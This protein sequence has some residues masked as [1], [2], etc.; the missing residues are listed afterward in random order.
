MKIFCE[1]IIFGF[2]GHLLLSTK[3]NIGLGCPHNLSVKFQPDRSFIITVE[4]CH[5]CGLSKKS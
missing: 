4:K 1:V 2:I 5:F 3:C